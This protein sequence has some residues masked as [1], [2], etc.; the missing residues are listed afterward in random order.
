M[1]GQSTWSYSPYR[2]FLFDTGEVYICRLA[3]SSTAIHVEW[4]GDGTEE[5]SVFARV[6]GEGEFALAGSVFGNEFDI[7]VTSVGADYEI[8]VSCGEKMSRIRLARAEDA[9]GTVINYLHPED[10]AYSFS[11]KYLCS[12]SL[13]KHPDGYL[14]ASMDLFAHATCQNL[15]I[16][17]RSDDDGETWHYLTELMPCFWGKLFLHKGEVYMLGVSTEYGDLLISRSTDGGK[18]F[19][20]PVALLRGTGGKSGGV[21]VHKNPQPVL[22]YNGRIYE[23]LEWGSW[24]AK[25]GYYHAAMV[26]SADEDSDLLLPESWSFTEP[27]KYDPTWEGAA[28]DGEKACIEG[29]L[30]VA[31]DGRL[32]NIMRYQ[33]NEKRALAFLVN[34]EDHDAPLEYSHAID[35]PGNLSK[36][37]IKFDTVSGKYYSII[38]RRIDEPRTVRNL[39][40]LVCSRDL[41][42][43]ELVTDLIDRRHDDPDFV[44]FQYVDF[45]F[46]GDDIIYQ[47]RTAMNGANNFHDANYATFHNIKDFR[48]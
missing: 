30:A 42:E 45:E 3:P 24:S 7:L 27:L 14:L 37:M 36:F 32:Y 5:Y 16:I 38:C 41:C 26:M 23:T 31:P 44:G 2:P 39:L 11:G 19:P 17:F 18:T 20:A 13:L 34:T 48:G 25:H 35:F 43:W 6:R 28:P 33:T 21:G 29:T 15:T 22:Y 10:D 4:L 47:S 12:P 8:Y 9:V 46:S 40:S 1:R